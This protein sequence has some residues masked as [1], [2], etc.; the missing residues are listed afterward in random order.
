MDSLLPALL[1]ASQ[2]PPGT[3]RNEL[4]DKHPYL[5]PTFEFQ[6]KVGRSLG[7]QARGV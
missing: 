5:G 7:G 2:A 4:V 1:P 6:E 3:K